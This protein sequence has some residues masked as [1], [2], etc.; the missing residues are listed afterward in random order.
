M[1]A[2][3][4]FLGSVSSV[5]VCVCVGLIWGVIMDMSFAHTLSLLTWML[6]GQWGL[7]WCPASWKYPLSL[8]LPAMQRVIFNQLSPL[9]PLSMLHGAIAP[10]LL[11]PS[12][13]IFIFILS[14]VTG[15]TDNRCKANLWV[16]PPP[17]LPPS[18]L[19]N[20]K[21]AHPIVPSL[22][23]LVF[24]LCSACLS[25]YLYHFSGLLSPLCSPPLPLVVFLST[26]QKGFP[27]RSFLFLAAAQTDVASWSLRCATP[28]VCHVE[29]WH[30]ECFFWLLLSL[31]YCTCWPCVLWGRVKH[32]APD[33]R[34]RTK[35]LTP[36]IEGK[37]PQAGNQPI[38]WEQPAAS[39]RGED[40]SS[41]RGSD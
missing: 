16:A 33:R 3:A 17:L 23:P 10:T 29:L 4:S 24:L 41:S 36:W 39:R 18:A 5:C 12:H 15:G 19:S 6:S 14:L 8:V 38:T 27:A 37:L 21:T 30:I 25:L 2:S 34:H 7:H 28:G 31:C 35:K 40:W 13:F 9:H 26:S 1:W 20:K 11:P 32:T 22:F